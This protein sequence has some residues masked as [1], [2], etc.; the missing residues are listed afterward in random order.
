M[1]SD[2]VEQLVL[3]VF[4]EIYIFLNDVKEKSVE[5]I[6]GDENLKFV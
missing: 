6:I 2:I 5:E 1:C 4:S 3:V